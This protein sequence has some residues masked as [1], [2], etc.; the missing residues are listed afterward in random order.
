MEIV[1][2]GIL[3]IL[4]WPKIFDLGIFDLCITFI[5][6]LVFSYFN[7]IPQNGRRFNIVSILTAFFMM[8]SGI[9]LIHYLLDIPTKLNYYLGICSYEAAM[10][11]RRICLLK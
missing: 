2:C 5:F 4:R 1:E 3:D 9:V 10:Q 6:A 7:E 8:M 11:N